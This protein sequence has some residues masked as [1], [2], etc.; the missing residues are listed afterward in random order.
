MPYGS[1]LYA[2]ECYGEICS[3]DV[4][5][6][7]I[8]T[9]ELDQIL[10]PGAGNTYETW[11]LL[12]LFGVGRGSLLDYS[13]FGHAPL[14]FITQRG[15]FQDGETVLDM[16]YDT[17]VAQIVIED[18]VA[19][20][21]DFWDRR[22]DLLDLL[23]PNRSF[24][25]SVRP[26]IYRKWL[27][28]GRIQR[29]A[30]MI[31]TTGSTAVTSHDGRFIERGLDPGAAVAIGGTAYIIA[32][33]PND[34][35]LIV[36]TPYPGVSATNVDWEYRRGWGKRD[37]YCLL[38]EGPHF[39]ESAGD[40]QVHRAG[41]R[42]ALRFVA[43]DPFWYGQTQSET[44]SIE[45]LDALIFDT[46]GTSQVRAWFGESRGIGYWFF[47]GDS[48]SDAI[49]IVY[50]GTVG[51]KPTI[52]IDG[53][54]I[55]PSIENTTIDARIDLDYAIALGE[56]VTIDTLALTAINNFG[57]NIPMTGDVATFELSPAPQA[58]NRVNIIYVSFSGGATGQSAVTLNWQNR[59]GGM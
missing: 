10:I 57:D 20:R 22:A 33:V 47:G 58:P 25:T 9:P 32:G 54:A 37:L 3:G 15:P 26:L 28:A 51:A 52:V 49:E 27:P 14:H 45:A 43:H 30:D 18:T 39:N 24:G 7:C 6:D 4:W 2:T 34:Y 1:F 46:D 55:N 31:V 41:Y 23:R 53:P 48:V 5:A 38:E 12:T 19:N 50:W 8:G 42:E 44:W 59:Y 11:P 29:G 40:A 21:T 56:Q 16:R 35:T 13:G 17:R 36:D